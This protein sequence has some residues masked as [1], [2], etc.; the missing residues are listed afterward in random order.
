MASLADTAL[1]FLAHMLALAVIFRDG[2]AQ[3]SPCPAN[4][5]SCCQCITMPG[6]SWYYGPLETNV[7][8]LPR[9]RPL[10]LVVERP[11]SYSQ[12]YLTPPGLVNNLDVPSRMDRPIN[13]NR[14]RLLKPQGARITLGLGMRR[15][16]P[17]QVKAL[18]RRI[19]IKVIGRRDSPEFTL[20]R[21]DDLSCTHR[22][23]VRE[24]GRT[25]GDSSESPR[26]RARGNPR[27]NSP[28]K[29][30]HVDCYVSAPGQIQN[31]NLVV[32]MNRC[33]A[34]KRTIRIMLRE[35]RQQRG[36]RLK[37][38]K[39]EIKSACSCPCQGEDGQVVPGQDG[40]C[41]AD[42]DR[43][44]CTS[45]DEHGADSSVCSGINRY[46]QRQENEP[47]C[48]GHG[49]CI[50]SI[51]ICN[52]LPGQSNQVILPNGSQPIQKRYRGGHCQCDDTACPWSHGAI[53][54]GPN[55]G[56]CAC[57]VCN[58]QSSYMGDA[59]EWTTDVENCINVSSGEICSNRGQCTDNACVCEQPFSGALCE[60]CNTCT[61]NCNTFRPCIECLLFP[62]QRGSGIN[63]NDICA[64]SHPN[65]TIL[66]T[67]GWPE[68]AEV[69]TFQANGCFQEYAYTTQFTDGHS[70][71]SLFHTTPST[72]SEGPDE[73]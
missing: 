33:Y 36:P 38:T 69:C 43:Q 59:C 15:Q 71:V 50:C 31:L 45:V 58:C 48:S 4:A 13:E 23:R 29:Q 24:R 25:V 20:Q 17:I 9:C 65:T 19:R 5:T 35:S 53:C 42:E 41:N 34:G 10:A 46:C 63:C 16:V 32:D 60:E 44:T 8:R 68:T 64:A 47:V 49:I 22:F 70:H 18:R 12:H 62:N 6:C 56:M 1:G 57:G 14:R 40:L 2:R 66:S 27:R 3:F 51:C 26:N 11:E 28:L 61:A 30:L 39:V 52:V 7:E 55:R 54:G 37:K 72:C 21:G 67:D 73:F